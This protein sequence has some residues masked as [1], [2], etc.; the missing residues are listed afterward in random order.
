MNAVDYFMT[1]PTSGTGGALILAGQYSSLHVHLLT[2][3]PYIPFPLRLIPVGTIGSSL[4]KYLAKRLHC[5]SKRISK[6]FEGKNYQGK[7]LYLREDDISEEEFQRKKAH[8]RGLKTKYLDSVTWAEKSKKPKPKSVPS[9]TAATP[10]PSPALEADPA[11]WSLQP[12]SSSSSH[13]LSDPG[14]FGTAQRPQ[15]SASLLATGID[16]FTS[17]RNLPTGNPLLASAGGSNVAGLAGLN[18]L[19]LRRSTGSGLAPSNYPLHLGHQLQL[20]SNPLQLG[21]NPLHFGLGYFGPLPTALG[22]APSLDQF[23][24]R[25]ERLPLPQDTMA[26]L[27]ALSPLDAARLQ[28]L[29]RSFNSTGISAAQLAVSRELASSISTASLPSLGDPASSLR[30]QS[31]LSPS[32]EQHI[33]MQNAGLSTAAAASVPAGTHARGF[34]PPTSQHQRQGKRQREPGDESEEEKDSKRRG[35]S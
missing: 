28:V 21:S 25:N 8:L 14:A 35:A 13:H 23:L 24:G 29:Q 2:I 34:L 7:L 11:N 1:L 33:L 12:G 16:N 19:M 6:K 18:P 31:L 27:S 15:S 22:S 4:R 20:G 26:S 30:R 10:V 17:A 5:S 9:P 3:R 32:L